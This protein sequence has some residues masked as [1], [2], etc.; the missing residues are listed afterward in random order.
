MEFS[1]I[2]LSGRDKRV[3]EALVTMPQSSIRRLAEETSIN[4]GSV[5]ESI[6]ALQRAGLVTMITRGKRTMYRAKDPEIL[7]EI[8]A[9]KRHE[10]RIADASVDDYVRSFAGQ[11][12]DPSLFHFASFYEGD[13]GLAAVLR[14]VLKTCRADKINEY[15]AISSPSV[16]EYLYNNFRHFTRE[17]IR[18]KLFVRV[19]RQAG[20]PSI[21]AE[22]AASHEM[23]S[24][25]Y[26][27]RCYTL[28]YGQKVALITLDDM[29][30]SSGVIIDNGNF[31]N[32]QQQLFNTTWSASK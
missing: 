1:L 7:H 13:E 16:S 15:A 26:D 20:R 23:S 31:A 24:Q 25:P 27:T 32:I 8:L 6:K 19:L 12:N 4:R 9:E 10:L 21:E 5:Y 29:N 2:G 3:Y 22:Y 18:Q 14:D 11:A 17:R 30:R 28:I